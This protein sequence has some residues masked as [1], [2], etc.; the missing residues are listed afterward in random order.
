MSESSIEGGCLCGSIRYRV[1]GAPLSSGVCHCRSC[2]RAAGAPMLPYVTFPIAHF[3]LIKG[4]PAEFQSSPPVTRSFCSRCGTSLTYR[5]ADYADRIDVM[6]CTL[7]D[8]ERFPPTLHIWTSH[9]P[10]WIKIADGLPA[11]ATSKEAGS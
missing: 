5:H 11:Y 10:A 2:R 1:G 8:P 7:D 6:S 3:S 9:K 4:Q